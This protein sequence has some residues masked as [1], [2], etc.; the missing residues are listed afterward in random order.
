MPGLCPIS[1]LVAA[2]SSASYY[3]RA[4]AR[5]ANRTPSR[6]TLLSSVLSLRHTYTTA[7]LPLLLNT[8]DHRITLRSH[9]TAGL[10]GLGI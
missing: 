7:R 1:C 8:V 9:R 3:L 2:P 10:Q 5:Y 6:N 4:S